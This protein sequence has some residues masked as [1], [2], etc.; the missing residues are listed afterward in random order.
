VTRGSEITANP[1]IAETL[2]NTF[3]EICD[4]LLALNVHP[5]D[6][7]YALATVLTITAKMNGADKAS[8][9]ALM[10]DTIETIWNADDAALAARKKERS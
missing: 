5:G 8:I 9:Q 3:G 2:G 6:I 1:R 4:T 10:V 7:T